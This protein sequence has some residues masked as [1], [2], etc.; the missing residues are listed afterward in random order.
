MHRL[1]PVPLTAAGFAPF[2]TVIERPAGQDGRAINGGTSRRHDLLADLDLQAEGGCPTLALF[3]AQ[4]RAFPLRLQGLERHRLG[5]QTFVP[6]AGARCVIVVAPAGQPL[7]AEALQAFAVRGDQGFVLAPG[8]WHHAL[9]AIDEGDFVVIER[10]AAGVDCEEQ[11]LD[12]PV[13]L[14]LA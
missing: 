8:T 3:H 7:C 10:R 11:A 9:L 4:A 5:S 13:E 14:Q 2:G 6:L 1:L 12:G